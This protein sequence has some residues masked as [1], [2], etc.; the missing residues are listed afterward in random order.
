MLR[1]A[2]DLRIENALVGPVADLP[3]SAD[4]QSAPRL[5]GS[6]LIAKVNN[7]WDSPTKLRSVPVFP[8]Y[9]F[10]EN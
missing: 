1:R 2:I 4:W 8:P 5:D 10:P 9:G 6:F 7:W 3:F